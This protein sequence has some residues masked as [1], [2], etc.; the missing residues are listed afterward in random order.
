MKLKILKNRLEDNDIHLSFDFDYIKE[1]TQE[2]WK[3]KNK[4]EALNKKILSQITPYISDKTLK[5]DK[6]IK[7]FV[8]KKQTKGDDI[9]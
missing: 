3:S 1:V 5:G 4:T 2:I 7:L 9:A 6:N 8:D